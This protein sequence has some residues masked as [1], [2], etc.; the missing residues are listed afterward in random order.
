MEAAARQRH[1]GR[2]PVRF[3]KPDRRRSPATAPPRCRR[4]PGARERDQVSAGDRPVHRVDRAMVVPSVT[5]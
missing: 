4:R 1:A 2:Q 3:D 5:F